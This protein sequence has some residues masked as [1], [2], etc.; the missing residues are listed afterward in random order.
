MR[1]TPGNR[2]NLTADEGESEMSRPTQRSRRLWY[3]GL[4]ISVGLVAIAAAPAAAQAGDNTTSGVSLADLFSWYTGT[5]RDWGAGIF[6]AILGAVGAMV[7]VYTLIGGAMPGTKGQADIDHDKARVETLTTKL[8]ALMTNVKPETTAEIDS[9]S[10]A[11]NHLR[12]DVARERW[13]QFW[14]GAV[15]YLVLGAFFASM[16]AKNLLEALVIGAGWTAL[17]GS[18]GLKSE[19]E[20]R[21]AIKDA[22]ISKLQTAVTRANILQPPSDGGSNST[23]RPTFADA[24]GPAIEVL[25]LLRPLDEYV[26]AALHEG[27]LAIKV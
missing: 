3:A 14:L 6:Y 23:S 26:E 20:A 13:R 7:V 11:L 5:N 17:L 4:P 8:D 16:V 9:I 2:E 10:K 15:L 18:V 27:D 12:D 25:A 1:I 24:A 19:G 22:A 21:G